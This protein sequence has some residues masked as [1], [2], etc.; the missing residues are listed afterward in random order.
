MR[1]KKYDNKLMAA[2]I[3]I[4]SLSN[5]LIGKRFGPYLKNLR[6]TRLQISPVVSA[7]STGKT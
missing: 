1:I 7:A 5:Q 2:V 3:S 6:P 4:S